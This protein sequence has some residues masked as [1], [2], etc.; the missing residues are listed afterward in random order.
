MFL[1]NEK[2]QKKFKTTSKIFH[3]ISQKHAFPYMMY[4]YIQGILKTQLK[5]T[6]I[7]QSHTYI[8]SILFYFIHQV[9][10]GISKVKSNH[11]QT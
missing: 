3:Y 2:I 4:L 11:A 1:R 7:S 8:I 10:S 5:V 9:L 6:K